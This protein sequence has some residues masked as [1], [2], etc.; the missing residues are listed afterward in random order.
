M[1]LDK[2]RRAFEVEL[3]GLIARYLDEFDLPA[4]ALLD[5]V[6]SEEMFLIA[7]AF[8]AAEDEDEGDYI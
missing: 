2:Q 5:I 3:H 6:T 4:E 1:T 8:I 7:M